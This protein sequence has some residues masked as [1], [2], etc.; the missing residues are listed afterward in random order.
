MACRRPN[1]L[2]R[3]VL[4]LVR[5][6]AVVAAVLPTVG[7]DVEAAEPATKS[8][9]AQ[10][11][12]IEIPASW[13]I[14]KEET[15]VFTAR[16]PVQGPTDTF[17]ENVRLNTVEVPA[18]LTLERILEA[19]EK[20]ARSTFEVLGSGRLPG[21]KHE[22][23]WLAI[24]PKTTE[25][26][27]RRDVKIDYYF[28]EGRRSYALHCITPQAEYEKYRPLFEQIARSIALPAAASP[29]PIAAPTAVP[30]SAP[31]D[32][33]SAAREGGRQIGYWMFRVMAAVIVG[34]GLMAVYRRVRGG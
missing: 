30:Q 19:Q 17:H 12:R 7:S 24:A 27:E 8:Y 21:G 29:A 2:L 13:E 34:Y 11:V 4:G 1:S 31:R 14:V 5:G 25:A 18:G 33:R 28:V 10:G 3:L 6:L 32:E 26:G 16:E 22:M 9:E 20:D 23:A 15:T